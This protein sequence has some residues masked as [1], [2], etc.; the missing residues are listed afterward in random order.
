[1]IVSLAQRFPKVFV[2]NTDVLLLRY[3]VSVDFSANT[4]S[5]EVLKTLMKSEL[6][7]IV[8]PD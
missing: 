7:A 8:R 5:E 6:L 2:I 1:M 3:K 4:I